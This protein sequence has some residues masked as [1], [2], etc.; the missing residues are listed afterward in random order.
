MSK[1]ISLLLVC[2]PFL[3]LCNASISGRPYGTFEHPAARAR[4]RFR[5]WLP[6]ASVDPSTV[7]NDIRSAAN[8]GIGGIE[9][10]PFYNYGGGTP[11]V[12]WVKYGFGTPAFNRIFRAA[13][14]THRECGL[15]MDFA[16]GPNQG[17]GVPAET[18]NPGL[19]WDLRTYSTIVSEDA[20]FSHSIPGWGSGDLIAAVSALVLSETEKS[21]PPRAGQGPPYNY[22]RLVLQHD[23]LTDLTDS[24]SKT[25]ALSFSPP[26][27][28]TSGHYRIFASYQV[29]THAKNLDP[30]TNA[31][32]T[33]FD[34]GC[35][36]V[37]HFDGKG[38]QVVTDFWD[39]YI[40]VNGIKELLS[41]AG[42]SG[43]EDSME[44]LSNVSWS[45]SLP[46][47]F[48]ERWGYSIKPYVPLIIFGNNNINIQSAEPGELQCVL[49]TEDE[50]MGYVN[51]YRSSLRDGYAEYL[52]VF[53]NWTQS[54]LQLQHS[55]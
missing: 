43:W 9:L 25:G 4:P 13:L 36:I 35:Y 54:A 49:D 26:A 28:N 12:D 17:Q 24:V 44:L 53:T 33:I 42:N 39:R 10:L 46:A 8:L 11:V 18:D 23:S 16:M 30:D 6:D 31:T 14:E 51:A 38:A 40:L 7:Q 45:P 37:D 41:E 15:Y 48:E 3:L 29:L 5:Y 52:N 2:S 21:I 55:S 22:T 1:F 20:P 47:R 34:N 27:H 19:Q 50:G 32:N